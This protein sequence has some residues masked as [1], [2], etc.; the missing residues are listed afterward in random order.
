MGNRFFAAS[1]RLR[2]RIVMKYLMLW[3]SG[4]KKVEEKHGREMGGII[5]WDKADVRRTPLWGQ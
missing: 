3:Y 4:C 2:R 5:V 1:F